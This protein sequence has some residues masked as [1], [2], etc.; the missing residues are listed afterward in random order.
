M[1]M[2]DR[3]RGGRFLPVLLVGAALVSVGASDLFGQRGRAPVETK[4]DVAEKMQLLRQVLDQSFE[5]QRQ[6]SDAQ[7]ERQLT[8]DLLQSRINLIRAEIDGLK[9]K[10][11][12]QEA[13]ITE[14]DK[15]TDELVTENEALETVQAMQKE[16]V[17][18]Y[19]R[20]VRDVSE[21][22]PE[23]LKVKIQPLLDRLPD[24]A[25]KAEDIKASVSERYQT[26]L[27]ILNEI[28]KFNTD[29]HV[30]RERRKASDGREVEVDT[31]YVGLAKAYY[32][33]EGET[34]E[35]AGVGTVGPTGWAWAERPELGNAIRELIG[36][37]AG[38]NPAAFVVIPVTIE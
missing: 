28:N 30:V 32:A 26:V 17:D 2:I 8:M 4:E 21:R 13:S 3:L 24:P 35:I 20:R 6:I 5:I 11:T 19:E 15:E 37:H 27:G 18:N 14:A 25:T 7:G 23:V 31:M 12:E 34:A 16:N 36:V 22:L 33:G 10:T 38:K 1:R 29:I 9:E